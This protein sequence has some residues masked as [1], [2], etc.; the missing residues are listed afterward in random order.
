MKNIQASQVLAKRK[1]KK[2]RKYSELEA[3]QIA[4]E[5]EQERKPKKKIRRKI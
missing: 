3:E 1:S 4:T 5:M 2:I